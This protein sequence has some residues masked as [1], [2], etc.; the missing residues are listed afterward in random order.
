MYPPQKKGHEPRPYA[1]KTAFLMEFGR[2]AGSIGTFLFGQ[3][4][5]LHLQF[6]LTK[7]YIDRE[8]V[9]PKKLEAILC[10]TS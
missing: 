3:P 7:Y 10:Q 9:H 6:R 4:N 8:S 2:F 5:T 1:T